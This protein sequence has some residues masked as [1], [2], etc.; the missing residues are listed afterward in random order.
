MKG[1]F[2]EALSESPVEYVKRCS[3]G[4][5]LT[6]EYIVELLE[7]YR[8]MLDMAIHIA[9]K[10]ATNKQKALHQNTLKRINP[11]L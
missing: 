1:Y 4:Q 3:E 5:E 6:K 9:K 10:E 7:E 2:N 8:N 11:P